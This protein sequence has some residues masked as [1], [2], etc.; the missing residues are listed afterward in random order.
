[1]FE[2]DKDKATKN[3]TKHKIA[4]ADTFGV[5]EDPIISARKALKHEVK[6]YEQ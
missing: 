3:E 5:F 6:Q 4:F 2:W 1:M